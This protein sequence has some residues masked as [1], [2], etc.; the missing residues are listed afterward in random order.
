MHTTGVEAIK[1]VSV[2][3][4]GVPE[5][6]KRWTCLERTAARAKLKFPQWADQIEAITVYQVVTEPEDNHWGQVTEFI[7]KVYEEETH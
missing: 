7:R 1:L 5:T 3:M 2:D 6:F 4:T